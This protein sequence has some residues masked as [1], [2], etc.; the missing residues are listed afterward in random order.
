VKCC[1]N[2]CRVYQNSTKLH[3]IAVVNI[4]W[5]FYSQINILKKQNH[6][7]RNTLLFDMN[8]K[9]TAHLSLHVLYFLYL[10]ATPNV[11]LSTALQ[12]ENLFKGST[13]V[14][15]KVI[16]TR[17]HGLLGRLAAVREKCLFL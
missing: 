3:K 4:I 1:F 9:N 16:A 8:Y 6:T 11:I 14:T 5:P 2:K 13:N 12:N 10:F 15:E 7:F 17:L